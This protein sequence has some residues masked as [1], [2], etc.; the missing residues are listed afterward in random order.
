MNL[1]R[2]NSSDAIFEEQLKS[3]LAN[4]DEPTVER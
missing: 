1:R 3:L 4:T 2:L